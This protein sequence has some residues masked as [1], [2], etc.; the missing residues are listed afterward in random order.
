MELKNYLNELI[1]RDASDLYLLTGAPVSLKY[2]QEIHPLNSFDLP[3]GYVKSLAYELMTPAQV[4]AFEQDHEIT[5]SLNHDRDSRF[6]INIYNESNEVAMVVR[7]IR[8]RIPIPEALHL[9]D[10]LKTLVMEKRGL[11]LF[12][13]PTGV[14]KSTS[15]A[16]L[17]DHRNRNTSGH[18]IMIEDPIEYMHHHQ[19]SLITQRE[20]GIDCM[21]YANGLKNALRQS[22]D[23]I[24]IGEIRDSETMHQALAFSQAGHLCLST[25][26][27]TN[28][29]QSITRILNFYPESKRTGVLSDLAACLQG[30][31][32][33]RLVHTQNDALLPAFDILTNSPM[34]AE[35]LRRG[36]LDKIPEIMAKSGNLGMC[37]FDQSLLKLYQQGAISAEEALCYADSPNNLRLQINSTQTSAPSSTSLGLG[38]DDK[39]YP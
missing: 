1:S 32:S 39:F 17:I 35:L 31:V 19:K 7:H 34:V 33:Q 24:L 36:E 28:A 38:E 14:G 30:I 27:A 15:L 22:P 8:G 6:R 23:V 16:S 26:H 2:L 4:E 13:G 5:I 25:L 37:T 3:S 9:P 10:V 21:D 12:T 11:I 20:I 18:I 29:V